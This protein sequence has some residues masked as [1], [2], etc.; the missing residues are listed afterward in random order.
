MTVFA[1]DST[2][3][4]ANFVARHRGAVEHTLETQLPQ[5]PGHHETALNDAVRYAVFPGGK[6][7][8]PVLTL[9][10]NALFEGDV[11]TRSEEHTSELQSH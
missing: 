10:G 6:R 2:A 11:E 7:L 1:K 4:L 9:L 8:R 5:T 3:S